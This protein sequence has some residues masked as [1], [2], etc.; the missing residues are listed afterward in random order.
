MLVPR[1][2]R[3]LLGVQPLRVL[4]SELGW[5]EVEQ[6]PADR[7]REPRFVVAVV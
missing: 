2:E 1:L 7:P 6:S 3:P 4:H 5:V